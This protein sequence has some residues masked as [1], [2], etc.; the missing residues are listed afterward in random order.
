VTRTPLPWLGALLAGY[1]ALP[2]VAFVVRFARTPAGQLAAPGLGAALTTSLIT[3]SIAT[4]VVAVLGIPLAYVLAHARGVL[5]GVIGLV[6]QLPIALPPL[7]SGILLLYIVGPYTWLGERFHG[8]LTDDA[9][10]IVL[11]QIFVAAPFL[12][13]SARSA[14]AAADPALPGVAA[15]L[16]YGPGARFARVALPAAADALRA[17]LLLAWL[18]GFGEFGATVILAYHPYSLPVF[19]FVQFGSVGLAGTMLPTAAVLVSALVITGLAAWPPRRLWRSRT[20]ELPKARAP[21]P[22]SSVALDFELSAHQG[23]FRLR[24]GHRQR[25][26]ARH[27]AILGPSGAGKSLTV[28]V[29]AG[30]HRPDSGHVRLGAQNLTALAPAERTIGYLPQDPCLLPHLSVWRQV[31]FGVGTDPAV[32]A[33]WIELLG[34]RELVGRLPHELS[35][36]QRRRVALARALAREPRLLLLDEPFTGLDTPVRNELRRELRT[37]QRVTGLTTVLVTHDPD[38][39]ALLADEIVL[40][41]DGTVL[42]S[43]PQPEVFAHPATPTAARLLGARNMHTE[44]VRADG[45]LEIAGAGVPV[46]PALALPGAPVTWSVDP[47]DVLVAP[48]TGDGVRAGRVLDVI[49]LG[50][51]TELRVK[52]PDGQE[53]TAVVADHAHPAQNQPCTVTIPAKA[54]TFWAANP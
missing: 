20:R 31:T 44:P 28:R 34:L 24:A 47:R 51:I 15:T 14:F 30:L 46:D 1:L 19:T 36:G 45:T 7:I 29:I 32:A 27:L 25:G 8:N 35:G 12:I 9:T 53:L 52:L 10:G 13:V 42:Q 49:H 26:R 3:A 38:E 37:L 50:A 43:G 18:R 40:M 54:V 23:S 33:H 39:A 41:T 16:G 22:V 2:L 11:A 17:G 4:A 21:Q 48:S 6:V 5:A